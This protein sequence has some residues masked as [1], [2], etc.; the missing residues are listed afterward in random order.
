MR[1]SP[2]LPRASAASFQTD[3][4]RI[5]RPAL[6]AIGG[7]ASLAAGRGTRALTTPPAWSA[8][9]E[10]QGE[11]AEQHPNGRARPAPSDRPICSPV[12]MTAGSRHHW[13]A[14]LARASRARCA[15][16]RRTFAKAI[17][18]MIMIRRKMPPSTRQAT[19]GPFRSA[20]QRNIA[21]QKKP[22]MTRAAATAIAHH[23]VTFTT[24]SIRSFTSLGTRLPH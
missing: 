3:P 21:A 7:S 11:G 5:A 10:P 13:A 23:P 9:H 8:Q 4:R 2:G 24:V 16:R 19:I 20:I 6:S 17:A 1:R 14:A 12:A 15:R 22:S 18:A